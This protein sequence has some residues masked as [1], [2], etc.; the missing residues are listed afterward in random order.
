MTQAQFNLEESE[1]EFLDRS[2]ETLAETPVK[3]TFLIMKCFFHSSRMRSR[4]WGAFKNMDFAPR[5]CAALPEGAADLFE[6]SQSE[7]LRDQAKPG[8]A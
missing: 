1:I 3:S 5:A 2:E 8:T 6:V 4:L 7:A